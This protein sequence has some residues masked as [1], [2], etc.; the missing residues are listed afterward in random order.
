MR[1]EVVENT[2]ESSFGEAQ[3]L[4]RDTEFVWR[5]AKRSCH[6]YLVEQSRPIAPLEFKPLD[7]SLSNDISVK[8]V[9]I[10]LC[11]EGAP[12]VDLHG[13]GVAFLSTFGKA[14]ELEMLDHSLL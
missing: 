13:L 6:T 4:P 9:R 12:P 1:C 2:G 8:A 5:K 7:Y 11:C 3:L 10:D 14:S